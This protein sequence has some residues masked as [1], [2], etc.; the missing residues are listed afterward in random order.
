MFKNLYR[1]FVEKDASLVEINPLVITGEDKL[2]AVD[3]KMTF[4]NNALFRH[5]DVFEL[6]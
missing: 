6:F 3:A 2:S 1:L 5:P 4:D